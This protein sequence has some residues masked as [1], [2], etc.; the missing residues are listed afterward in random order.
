MDDAVFY[1]ETGG[2]LNFDSSEGIHFIF[3]E[4]CHCTHELLTLWILNYSVGNLR[5][6][7]TFKGR[8]FGKK[9]FK[10]KF[11]NTSLA[12]FSKKTCFKILKRA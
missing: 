1:S 8:F 11:N 10:A 9:N 3:V 6:L 7:Y 5:I 4:Y 2:L 12:S